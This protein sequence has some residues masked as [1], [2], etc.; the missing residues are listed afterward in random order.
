MRDHVDHGFCYSVIHSFTLCHP[1][2]FLGLRVL[3]ERTFQR[4]ESLAPLSQKCV[5]A[6]QNHTEFISVSSTCGRRRSLPS[7]LQSRRWSGMGE[8]VLQ[9]RGDD[10]DV[11]IRHPS[12]SSRARTL[13]KV[14]DAKERG[15]AYN[16]QTSEQ[17]IVDRDAWNKHLQNSALALAEAPRRVEV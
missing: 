7:H 6:H 12:G 5:T 9:V 1:L 3:F 13:W 11:N 4:R 15:D 14:R 10:K 16:D 8:L 2:T 17:K